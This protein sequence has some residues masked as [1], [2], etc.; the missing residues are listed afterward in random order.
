[1]NKKRIH[2]IEYVKIFSRIS[3][4]D[5]G[6]LSEIRKKYGFKSNYEI[7][8]YLVYCFLRVADPEHDNVKEPVPVE[9]EEMFANLSEADKHFMFIKSKKRCAHKSPDKP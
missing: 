6:R 2:K 1:M 9:I 4:A 7:V 3:K 8:K 5:Y